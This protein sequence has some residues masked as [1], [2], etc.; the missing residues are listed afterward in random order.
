M[1]KPL[2]EIFDSFS[3]VMELLRN[4]RF[5]DLLVHYERAKKV[6]IVGYEVRDNVTSEIM[7]EGDGRSMLKPADYLIAFSEFVRQ[8][9]K[10]IEAIGILL[11]KPKEWNTKALTELRQK[12]KQNNYDE[13]NLEKAHRI[14]YHKDAVDIISMVKHAAR[15]TEPLL[16]PEERVDIAIRKVT[17]GR[18]L[19]DEQ[20]KWMGYIKEHLKKNMTIDEDD[21]KEL[22]VF[23]DRGGLN[24]FK[25]VFAGEYDTIIKEINIAIAA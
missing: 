13:A 12:L 22:P 25:S 4:E 24:R 19:S 14:V 5:Q 23:A 11:N 21:L 16:S 20:Q 17:F 7:F 8:K 10:E 3:D 15:E 2:I 1:A 18:K 9:G 6:F